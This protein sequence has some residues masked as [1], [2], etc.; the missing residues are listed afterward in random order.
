M[1]KNKSYFKRSTG[2]EAGCAPMKGVITAQNTGKVY[3]NM[4]SMDVKIEGENVVRNL[5]I[6]THNHASIPG[7]SPTWPY[8]D[9]AAMSANHPCAK[10][11]A[12][13]REKCGPLEVHRPEKTTIKANRKTGMIETKTT[14]GALLVGETQQRQCADTP[15]GR[16]CQ[17][18]RKCMMTPYSPDRCCEGQTGH[19]LVE[20]HGF[21]Q[22]GDRGNPLPQ[23]P[24]YR[25]NQAPVVC[26][27]CP[28]GSRFHEEHGDLHSVQGVLE[29]GAMA[30]AP[31]GM[32]GMAWNYGEA[33]QAGIKAHQATFPDSGCS[34]DCL[35]HQLDRYHQNVV[36]VDDST[37]LRTGPGDLGRDP[38][39]WQRGLELLDQL[40]RRNPI[41][42]GA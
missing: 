21:C 31:P 3:F 5:D 13:E 29:L 17:K 19:H 1:L 38:S 12:R 7:N 22:E 25:E 35:K 32:Q 20:V 28:G 18:A 41:L 37:P 11:H 40:A 10:E 23:F 16:E 39:Q 30:K 27:K 9:E 4:W 14:G 8:I 15:E 33:R 6:T 34:E 42:V 24:D 26:A 36:H 2:D